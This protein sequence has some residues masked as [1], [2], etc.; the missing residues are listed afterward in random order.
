MNMHTC[1]SCLI[2]SV[3]MCIYYSCQTS[4]HPSVVV[5]SLS[6]SRI[7]QKP[8]GRLSPNI[9]EDVERAKK[10]DVAFRC[11]F[12]LVERCIFLHWPTECPSSYSWVYL[13]GGTSLMRT[14]SQ[15]QFLRI[16]TVWISSV[17]I[18]NHHVHNTIYKIVTDRRWRFCW[19]TCHQ[20]L[21][22]TASTRRLQLCCGWMLQQVFDLNRTL[23]STKEWESEV[24]PVVITVPP[25]H[26]LFQ[27]ARWQTPKL[28][29][30]RDRG[31][32]S[33]PSCSPPS[34]R[35]EGEDSAVILTTRGCTE[36]QM[37]GCRCVAPLGE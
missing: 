22:L 21:H 23:K 24:F 3:Q 12:N 4:S 34:S 18:R 14:L 19:D 5:F 2:R 6:V 30:W 10:G 32:R 8:P 36:Y 33:R 26:E 27:H 37:K 13:A 16:S 9:M 1:V 7:T 31:L 17:S 20:G 28:K 25:H 29:M 15:C 11:R 35:S